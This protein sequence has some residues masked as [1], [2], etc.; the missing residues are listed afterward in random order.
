MACLYESFCP[1]D[2]LTNSNEHRFCDIYEG[3]RI[4][5]RLLRFARCMGT[6]GKLVGKEQRVQFIE[7]REREPPCST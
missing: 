1:T 7:G 2:D 4:R 3:I 5:R 6:E